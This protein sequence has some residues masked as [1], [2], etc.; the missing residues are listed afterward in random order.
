MKKFLFLCFAICIAVLLVNCSDGGKGGDVVGG[1]DIPNYLCFTADADRSLISA[2]VF[3]GY[4]DPL[5]V[6]EYS[7]DGVNW[8]TFIIGGTRVKLNKGDKVYLKAKDKNESF[9]EYGDYIRFCMEG[10][11]VASG[12]IMSLLD[13]TCQ[14]VEIPCDYCFNNLFDRCISLTIAS[15]LLPATKLTKGCYSAMFNDCYNLRTAPELP[16]VILAEQ[17]YECMFLQCESLET[18]PKLPATTLAKGCY[19]GMFHECSKLTA[20]E[21]SF[22]DWNETEYATDGWLDGVSAAGTFVCPA[23]LDTSTK[24]T[25]HVPEN[26]AVNP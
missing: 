13:S 11:I 19:E 15:I 9:S 20:V 8:R 17:C 10:S 24:D 25:S 5:P 22:T 26:W 2:E 7:I 12:N 16:A 6:L 23:E 4:V 21:V 3:N 18:A 14:S 1:D